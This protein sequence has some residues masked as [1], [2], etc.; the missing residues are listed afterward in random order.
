MMGDSAV[1]RRKGSAEVGSS[2][3]ACKIHY[4]KESNIGA[5]LWGIRSIGNEKADLILENFVESN[6]QT[7]LGLEEC[8]NNLAEIFNRKFDEAQYIGEERQGG[9]HLCGY[10]NGQPKLWHVHW[11]ATANKGFWALAKDLPEGDELS[12]NEFEKLLRDGRSAQLA[13]GFYRVLNMAREGIMVY[14]NLLMNESGLRFPEDSIE[15][16]IVFVRTMFLM[17]SA[18]MKRT[19]QPQYVDDN[20]RVVVF[21]RLG[22]I[23]PIMRLS[24]HE[25]G[26]VTN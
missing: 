8:G 14:S 11:S 16:Q 10:I 24:M 23:K 25:E 3:K 13:N 4:L 22:L 1:V 9:I 17:V 5:A 12:E 2:D 21:D 18:A 19:D 26:V 6:N 7:V 15:G 20:I